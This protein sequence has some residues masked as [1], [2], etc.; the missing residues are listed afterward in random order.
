MINNYRQKLLENL[1][2]SFTQA[3][4]GINVGQNFPFGNFML[5][6]Q[7]IMILLFVYN[8]KEAT[9]IKEIAKFLNVTPGA[10]TQFI[11]GLVLKKLVRREE[12]ILDRRSIN[13]RLTA[14][15]QKQF[16]DFK[17]IYFASA[18]KSFEGL[19][20]KE[21]EQFIELVKK[22]SIPPKK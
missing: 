20:N 2:E 19:N 14:A 7:Q 3:I 13:I 12:N 8:K 10:V 11:D 21:L 4:H 15:T 6:R 5:G 17:K 22:I 1:I 16:N 9:P 18:S